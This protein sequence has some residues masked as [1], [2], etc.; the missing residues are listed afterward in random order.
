MA[1]TQ[2]N[3]KKSLDRVLKFAYPKGDK[4][5]ESLFFENGD[6]NLSMGNPEIQ[7]EL[8]KRYPVREDKA[9][10]LPDE[11]LDLL[12]WQVGDSLAFNLNLTTNTLCLKKD[13]PS[14]NG[15]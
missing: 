2:K 14:E 11:V 12:H 9:V 3:L 13:S 8:T 10:R 5:N 4:E 6:A 1:E 15:K 7:R